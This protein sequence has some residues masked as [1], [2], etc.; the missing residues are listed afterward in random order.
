M[1]DL[2]VGCLS[3]K[4]RTV[5]DDFGVDLACCDVDQCHRWLLLRWFTDLVRQWCSDVVG[6][7]RPTR[8][9][10]ESAYLT[11]HHER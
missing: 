6:M 9:R 5:I 4:P 11:S 3:R 8:C 10:L 7:L 1:Y 2:K